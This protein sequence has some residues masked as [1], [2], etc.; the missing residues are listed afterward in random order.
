MTS[1]YQLQSP[2]TKRH[3]AV[4]VFAS[5]AETFND[6]WQ[7]QVNRRTDL[8]QCEPEVQVVDSRHFLRSVKLVGV[9]TG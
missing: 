5:L 9:I 2:I 7:D 4:P 1:P 3:K 6:C 8:F